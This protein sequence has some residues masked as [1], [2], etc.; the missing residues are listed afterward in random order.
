[1][2]A[3][4]SPRLYFVSLDPWT[5]ITLGLL[6]IFILFTMF[7]PSQ[8]SNQLEYYFEWADVLLVAFSLDSHSSLK[9]ATHLLQFSSGSRPPSILVATKNDSKGKRV[10]SSEEARSV[11]EGLNVPYMETSAA[12]NFN[13]KE[14][15]LQAI[16]MGLIDK[17]RHLLTESLFEDSGYLSS[18]E[19]KDA[20][21]QK[22]HV[23]RFM[24]GLIQKYK[25]FRKERK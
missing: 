10:I 4:A 18:M 13:V 3:L 25:G 24:K 17:N 5:M 8:E 16:E 6:T 2:E 9:Y 23:R 1:M 19:K 7:S 11:A 21:H 12:A 20:K 22:P 15:F 14:A